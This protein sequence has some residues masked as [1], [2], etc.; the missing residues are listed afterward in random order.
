MT[1]LGERL[2]EFSQAPVAAALFVL[3]ARNG[4][5][6]DDLADP[7]TV[8]VLAS[9]AICQLNPWCGNGEPAAAR[10]EAVEAVR[11]QQRLIADVLADERNAWWAAPLH[12]DGQLLLTDRKDAGVDPMR[13]RAPFGAVSNWETYAQ[14][15]GSAV[16]TSTELP[17]ADDPP[18]R[19]GAHAELCCGCGDWVVDYPVEQRRLHAAADARV[20]EVH[21][22]ADWHAL[23]ARYGDSATHGGS[24]DSLFES[25]ELVN[26]LAP[27]WSAVAADQDGVHLSFAGLLTALY[28]PFSSAGIGTTTLWAWSWECTFWVHSVFTGSDLLPAL[29]AAPE[30]A[31]DFR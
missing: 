5:R 27:T 8:A 18:I 26:G 29:A 17:V 9:Q 11:S 31:F 23:V 19:S 30:C 28:V 25:A 6:P 14:K 10:R 12:R 24:D 3:A 13:I 4:L 21:S 16:I 20:Y 1:E 22:A 15:P 7:Q 2:D